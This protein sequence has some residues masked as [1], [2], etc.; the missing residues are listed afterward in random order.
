MFSTLPSWTEPQ[1]QAPGGAQEPGVSGRLSQRWVRC[2][3][4]FHWQ[5]LGR[6]AG[7]TRSLPVGAQR[8]TLRWRVGN[9]R[10]DGRSGRAPGSTAFPRRVGAEPWPW[11]PC[12]V[13]APEE[14]LGDVS[15]PWS[16]FGGVRVQPPRCSRRQNVPWLTEGLPLGVDAQHAQHARRRGSAGGAELVL[17][18][19]DL[20]WT[21]SWE[22]P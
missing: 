14:R 10:A 20:G 12:P 6:K 8:F 22:Q 11:R 16:S 2:G 5:A 18:R 17:C 1:V 9:D 19:W 7:R 15:L 3:C 21:Q 4:S 13:V